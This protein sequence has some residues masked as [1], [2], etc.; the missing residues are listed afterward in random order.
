MIYFKRL[1]FLIL[2]LVV[3]ILGFSLIPV[4][5]ILT[6]IYFFFNYIL[7]GDDAQPDEFIDLVLTFFENLSKYINK[8]EP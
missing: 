2:S 8:I 7:N 5:L 4:F 1:L 3:N 6:P